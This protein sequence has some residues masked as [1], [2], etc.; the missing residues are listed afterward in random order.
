MK[1]N[2]ELEVPSIITA[3]TQDFDSNES[4]AKRKRVSVFREAQRLNTLLLWDDFQTIFIPA[5]LLPVPSTWWL[6]SFRWAMQGRPWSVP[7]LTVL[8]ERVGSKDGGH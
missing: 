5:Y 3:P 2:V 1:G 8:S 4:E 6:S 7:S